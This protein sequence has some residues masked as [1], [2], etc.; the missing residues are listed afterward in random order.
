M[1]ADHLGV[2]LKCRFWSSWSE[3]DPRCCVSKKLPMLQ[4][5]EPPTLSSKMLE[6]LYTCHI[7][8]LHPLN[9]GRPTVRTPSAPSE[10][11][12]KSWVWP[13]RSMSKRSEGRRKLRSEVFIPMGMAPY[14]VAVGWLCPSTKD[15]SSYQIDLSSFLWCRIPVTALSVPPFG[16]GW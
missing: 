9:P 6:S 11:L 8:L 7:S 14:W 10:P 1:H 16:P 13:T 5:Q 4:G 15:Y 3:V 2:M 12:V